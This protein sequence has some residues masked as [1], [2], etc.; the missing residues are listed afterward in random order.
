MIQPEHK[1]SRTSVRVVDPVRAALRIEQLRASLAMWQRTQL[2]VG[3]MSVACV[4]AVIEAA[5]ERKVPL[6]LIASRRQIECAEQGGGYVNGW[7]TETFAEY[8][9]ARDP[10][11]YVLL[12]RDHG[13]PWQNY[14]EVEHRMSGRLA[15]ASA[16]R[17][18]EV[19]IAEGFDLI[20]LDPSVP[21]PGEAD[22]GGVLDMLFDLY[23]FTIDAA[24]RHGRPIVIEV[25]SE[26][27]SGG[28]NSPDELD[29]FLAKLA[30]F[31][32]RRS[33]PMPIFVVAQTGTLV[34]ETR[35]IGR[36]GSILD[37]TG[38][39]EATKHI[40]ELTQVAARHGVW[41]KEHNGDYLGDDLIRLRP[42]MRIGGTNVAPQFGVAETRFLLDICASHGLDSLADDFLALALSSRK[43]EK[44]LLPGSR[45]SDR[46]K[47]ILAGH[48]VFAT[49]TFADLHG[50]MATALA[51]RGVDLARAV[52]DHLKALIT[53]L[54]ERLGL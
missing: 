25:G 45:A 1:P 44:W 5:N 36:L 43:W 13:G 41:I 39:A 49:E 10:G 32:G 4:D 3:P 21:P 20:H 34:R 22:A 53:G 17:S 38:R 2:G 18:L 40:A 7:T 37:E 26:E 6:M 11:D 19:D 42:T 47:A 16:K 29:A 8:V 30:D 46:D 15:M 24:R 35:N 54:A 31:C 51:R 50:R 9:R 48:Y 27:Q 23:D 33:H 28:L 52:R 12:C 14:P